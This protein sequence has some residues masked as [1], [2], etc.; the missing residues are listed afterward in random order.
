[1]VMKHFLGAVQHINI[2]MTISKWIVLNLIEMYLSKDYKQQ[3]Y[4]GASCF[5]DSLSFN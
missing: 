5:T 2:L 4:K 1:M 3:Y